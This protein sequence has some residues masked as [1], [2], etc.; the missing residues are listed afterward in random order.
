[1]I[2]V[3]HWLMPAV[4]LGLLVAAGCQKTA[5]GLKD[6]TATN[7]AETKKAGEEAGQKAA[8]SVEN[9]NEKTAAMANDASKT[10]A[11]A[12]QDVAGA[13]KMTP[14]IKTALTADVDLNDSKN[15]IDVDSMDGVVHLKGYVT[16]NT[17]KQ[18][19]TEIAKKTIK[20]HNGTDTVM[21]Q[22]LVKP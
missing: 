17:L 2:F 9:A 11:A 8:Q 12:G 21:N 4:A 14:L 22:L 20:E 7:V 16:T 3:K 18:R 15:K 5:E 6:D 13:L 1:M 19:A 10:M